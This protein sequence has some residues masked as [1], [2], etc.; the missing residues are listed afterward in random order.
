MFRRFGTIFFLLVM[1]S[2]LLSAWPPHPAGM[3]GC[4]AEC[5]ATTHQAGLDATRAGLCCM[6]N[7]PPPIELPAQTVA[8]AP[9]PKQWSGADAIVITTSVPINYLQHTRFPSAPTRS[10]HGSA[11]RYLET[12]ALLI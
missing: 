5:C 2:N 12:G 6:L 10:L 3:G 9:A 7:C 8:L 4:D 1:F 11:S